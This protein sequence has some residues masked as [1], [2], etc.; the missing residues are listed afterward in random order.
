MNE[1][2]ELFT[3]GIVGAERGFHGRTLGALSITGQPKYRK[4]FEPLLAG[5]RF[6]PRGDAA[7]LESAVNERTAGIVGSVR[8][9]AQ[10]QQHYRPAGQ[11]I[12]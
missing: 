8:E 2:G 10:V 12:G 9:S 5:V 7:A 3:I 11:S 6:V 1:G 4:D